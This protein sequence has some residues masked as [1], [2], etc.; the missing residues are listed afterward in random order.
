MK[1]NL[2]NDEMPYFHDKVKGNPG[3]S[4]PEGYFETLP[5]ILVDKLKGELEI[6]KKQS[7][8]RK[9]IRSL[10]HATSK[11]KWAAAVTLLLMGSAYFL[12][13]DAIQ[14]TS[15]AMASEEE[16]LQYFI[17]DAG[18]LSDE[19]LAMLPLDE[20]AI[21]MEI[22]EEELEDWIENLEDTDLEQLLN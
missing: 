11:L 1:A 13:K 20:D 15:E 16:I 9:S 8:S 17:E 22:P 21:D 14:P 2:E 4:V 12:Q 3:F 10:W 7:K 19:E 5:D 6:G 18:T